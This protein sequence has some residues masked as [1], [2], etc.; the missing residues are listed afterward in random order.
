MDYRIGL[1]S[2]SAFRIAWKRSSNALALAILDLE[3]F[4]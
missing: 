4:A 3:T 2:R 1:R